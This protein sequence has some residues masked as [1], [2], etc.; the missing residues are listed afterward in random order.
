[1]FE[2]TLN[3]E[4]IL[5]I[6]VQAVFLAYYLSSDTFPGAKPIDFAFV[7][8]LSISIGKPLPIILIAHC[9]KTSKSKS[10]S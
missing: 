6:C 3:V 9:L 8:G 10:R 7:G 4:E 1:M 2:K 5:T